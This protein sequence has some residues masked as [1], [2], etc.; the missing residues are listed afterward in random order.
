MK[1]RRLFQ[2]FI[3]VL[4]VFV[5]V[6]TASS[7]TVGA[8]SKSNETQVLISET[9][10][11]RNKRSHFNVGFVRVDFKKNTL[12]EDAYPITFEVDVYAENGK[13][14]IEF[15]PD[16]DEFFNDVKITVRSYEGFIYDIGTDEYILVDID[17]TVFYVSHFSR[18]CFAWI[19]E[20]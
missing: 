5:L 8:K 19:D 13:V 18:W 12:P 11:L 10:T 7:N 15:S 9:I 17:R 14:Y 4:F 1:M 2:V 16:V 20:K 3:L 6:N